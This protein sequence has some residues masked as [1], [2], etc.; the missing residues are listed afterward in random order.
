[1]PGTTSATA[2]GF[3]DVPPEHNVLSSTNGCCGR[4]DLV[5]NY[6][7]DMVYFDDHSAAVRADSGWMRRAL[8]QQVDRVARR[9]STSCH[10]QASSTEL[11]RARI[12]QDVERGF[13]RQARCRSPGRPAPASAA[14]TTTRP[15]Y[16]QRRLQEREAGHADAS[17]TWCPRT[18]ILLLNI[19]VRGD[20][21][22]DEKE[23]AILDQI[24]A[25]NARNG[26]AIFGTRPWRPFGEGPTKRTAR[27]LRR[28]AKHKPFTTEDVRFTKKARRALRDLPRLA[29]VRR[30]GSGRLA[31]RPW[32]TP[33]SSASICSADRS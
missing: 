9:A 10:R 1:M 27:P 16:E 17:P 21:T 14:G 33:R 8:L 7:P 25:W 4:M 29:A 6:R 12:D 18:A 11:Q 31:P 28:K 2:S 23:E 30:P 20:G 22:I 24:A 26:E 13:A 15:L 32:G 3:E 5:E 19:P